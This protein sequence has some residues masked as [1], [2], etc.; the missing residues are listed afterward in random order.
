MA[1]DSDSDSAV[2]RA[3]L[4]RRH[5]LAAYSAVL[6]SAG[7]LTDT[8]GC[9]AAE[10][11]A[12]REAAGSNDSKGPLIAHLTFDSREAGPG[13]LFACKGVYFKPQYLT[14]AVRAGAVA[15]VAE[16]PHPD[17]GVPGLIVRDIR[18]AMPLL[19]D[20]FYNHPQQYL[21]LIGITGTKGKTTTATALQTILNT[22]FEKNGAKPCGLLSTVE[23]Y[24]G[25]TT[26][27][28]SLTTP[29]ALVLF[30]HLFNMAAAGLTHAIIEC[31]SSALK[32]NRLDGLHFNY[33]LFLNLTPDHI[34]PAEHPDFE[35]YLAS[36]CR[37]L[38]ACDNAVLS[39]DTEA[40]GALMQA[41]AS[42]RRIITFSEKGCPGAD[43]TGSAEASTLAG[44]N[45]TIRRPDA[46]EQAVQFSVPG[47]FNLGN[48]LAAAV[49]AD[50]I[51]VPRDTLAEALG[52]V[53]VCG[54]M[55]ITVSDDRH[56]VSVVDYAHNG[57]SLD[58][59]YTTVRELFPGYQIITFLAAV[60]GRSENRIRELADMTIRHQ[61]EF[62][63]ISD[64]DPGPVD[65]AVIRNQIEAYLKPSGLPYLNADDRCRATEA[66]FR[67]AAES[68]RPTVI[69]LLGRAATDAMLI[70]G[71]NIPYPSD[72][73]TAARCMAAYNQS[74]KPTPTKPA[75]EQAISNV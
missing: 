51:G 3:A 24:D 11:E 36:K 66:A 59:L 53:F 50:Q 57:I 15:Y 49:C 8:A 34:S 27:P 62:T 1:F 68:S 46:S 60:G 55:N 26:E 70:R 13:T 9:P 10:S 47:A 71:Q 35:D 64:D 38:K 7:L 33:A 30:R 19:A 14:D 37:L 18:R 43:Y 32:F 45:L 17:A 22:H 40:T 5:E 73:E 65:A 58:H 12:S 75:A 25:M 6:R 56:I 69:L 54:R 44:L 67:R 61:I 28:A 20:L 16:H 41:A 23:I 74:M 31:S 21:T 52:Q 39:L 42:C 72:I 4:Y 2:S 63:Y 29:E 48:A